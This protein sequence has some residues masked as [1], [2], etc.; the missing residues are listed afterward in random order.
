MVI[1]RADW[2][3]LA[4]F[5][6]LCFCLGANGS[7]AR[8]E[9]R[10][11][12]LKVTSTAFK[13]G[14]AMASKY[15]FNGGNASPPIAWNNAPEGTKS[16]ALICDDPDAPKGDWVHWVIYYIPP[17]V[18]S[19]AE[20]QPKTAALPNGAKQGTNEFPKI[21]YD[22]PAPPSGTHRYF[23]RV[24]ALNT[25]LNLQPSATKQQLLKAMEGHVLAHGQVMGK[26]S[27]R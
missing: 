13:D 3:I 11:V 18:K 9:G 6:L 19:L 16:F 20:H 2:A 12:D 22:G 10:K 27:K 26:F 8:K 14:E 24:F 4:V 5:V 1:K 17:S 21:G 23:F 7:R 15:S 25:E